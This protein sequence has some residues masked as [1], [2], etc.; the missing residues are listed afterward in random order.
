MLIGGINRVTVIGGIGLVI[1]ICEAG[2]VVVMLI[3]CFVC[4]SSNWGAVL[5]NCKLIG[6]AVLVNSIPIGGAVLAMLKVD[7]G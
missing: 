3:G 1:S 7:N 2:R 5:L 4:E 6:G